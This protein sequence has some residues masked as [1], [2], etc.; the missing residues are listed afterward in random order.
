MPRLVLCTGAGRV[1]HEFKSLSIFCWCDGSQPWNLQ[2]DFT[3]VNVVGLK[4]SSAD[5]V[6][7]ARFFALVIAPKQPAVKRCGHQV[8]AINRVQRD[9]LNMPNG[10]AVTGSAEIK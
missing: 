1:F 9:A 6:I 3:S 4:S 7:A 10:L 2:A 5:A 8:G